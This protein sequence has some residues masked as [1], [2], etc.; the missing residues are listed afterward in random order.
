MLVD[1]D[2][3]GIPE[4]AG[5]VRDQHRFVCVVGGDAIPGNWHGG[6]RCHPGEQGRLPGTR[7]R[8]DQAE[9]AV[10]VEE[11]ALQSGSPEA[12]RFWAP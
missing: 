9:A 10:S 2:T 7:R 3:E 5:Q 12:G 6:G 11:R 1:V 8:H 4:R